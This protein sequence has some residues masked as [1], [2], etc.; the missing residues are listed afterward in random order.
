MQN[1]IVVSHT[2]PIRAHVEEVLKF[3]GRWGSASLRED[4]TD[5][6]E[7]RYSLTYVIP[8]NFVALYVIRFGRR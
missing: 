2:R 3:S 7:T 8:P 5:V 6:L 1:L 4:V